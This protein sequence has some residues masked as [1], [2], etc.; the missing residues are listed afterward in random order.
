MRRRLKLAAYELVAEGGL[1]ALRIASVAKRAEVSQGA[2]L[3]HFPNKDEI[4]LAAIEQALTMADEDS[5]VWSID[6]DDPARLLRSMVE[7][8]KTFFFSDRFWVAISITVEFSKSKDGAALL[9]NEVT[10]LR[11]PV[12][13]EWVM[14]LT[15]AGWT[16]EDALEIVRSAAALISGTAIRRL[17]ATPD[18]V[19][20]DI[21]AHWFEHSMHRNRSNAS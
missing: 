1:G 17:W 13:A 7:E 4:T 21:L 18:S 19:A 5:L 12:Y 9:A 6:C 8:F 11:Q 10:K 16:K 14:K 15:K 3:H 2:V 20:D